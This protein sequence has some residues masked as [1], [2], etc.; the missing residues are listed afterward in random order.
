MSGLMDNIQETNN[1]N[2]IKNDNI[3]TILHS[4]IKNP[5]PSLKFKPF[6][7]SLIQPVGVGQWW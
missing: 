3:S 5:K 6:F 4:S 1:C 2:L 7:V